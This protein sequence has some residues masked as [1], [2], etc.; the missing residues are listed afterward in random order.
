[1]TNT[2]SNPILIA[3]KAAGDAAA[4]LIEKGMVV[5]LGTGSTSAFFIEALGK[6]C[7]E[8]L[9]ILAVATSQQ[10]ARQAQ[11]LG[12]PLQ[13]PNDTISIDITVDGADQIDHKKNMIKGGGG[14]LLREK[15]LAISSNE[16]IVIVDETKLVDHL[17]NYPVPVEIVPFL[18][19]NTVQRLDDQGYQ[20]EL[21]LDRNDQLFITDNGNLIF[22]IQFPHPILDIQKEHERLKKITGVIETGFFFDLAKRVIIGYEDGLTKI[23]S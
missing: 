5:G 9:D 4:G 1:M 11:H 8:G 6:R 3:K 23:Q 17:G 16:M 14:A 18:F 7:R 22:D 15:L 21:R 10:S 13:E 20:G 2:D 12:I 19:K